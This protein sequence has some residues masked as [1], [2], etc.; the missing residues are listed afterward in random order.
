MG[1]STAMMCV[2]KVTKLMSSSTEFRSRFLPA[3]TPA[4]AKRLEALHHKQHGVR[5]M[6][7][8]LDCSHFL[9]GNC[10]VAFHGQFQGKEEKRTIVMEAVCDYNRFAWHTV[11]GYSG[12]LNEINIWDTSLLHNAFCDGSFSQYDFPFEIGGETFETL[13]LLV[14]GIYP[15][16]ARFVKPLS[17]PIDDNETLFSLWQEAKRKDIE[18]FFGVFKKSLTS[19]P[20]QSVFSFLKK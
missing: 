12:V 6:I 2:K 8:S 7:G 1:E 20:T 13:W 19:L 16:L 15:S 5:G 9:W 18:R 4:D 14:D 3:I 11:Y 10:P 17:V